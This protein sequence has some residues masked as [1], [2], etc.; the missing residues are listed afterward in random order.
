MSREKNL[1]NGYSFANL[2]LFTGFGSGI[3]N[4]VYSL[5]IFDIFRLF[6]SESVSSVAVGVY[7]AVYALFASVVGIVSAEFLHRF[8]KTRLL[9]MSLLIL[10]A[11]YSMMSFSVKP[12]TFISLDYMANF[13]F[14]KEAG[15]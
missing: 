10:G 5:V 15:N 4:A 13:G 11:C 2:G 14:T 12:G 7:A 6:F 9:Y 3:V 8:T 1:L